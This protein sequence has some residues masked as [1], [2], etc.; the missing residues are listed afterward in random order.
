MGW[1]SVEKE[2]AKVKKILGIL[3][4]CILLV[5]FS[6]CIRSRVIITSNPSGA[7]VTF[8]RLYRGPTPIEIPIIWYWYYDIRLEKEGYKPLDAQERFHAPVWFYMP[9]DLFCEA[10]PFRIY[11]T[12][13]RHYVL[14]PKEQL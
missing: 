11:D 1:G 9:F 6:G 12:K 10:L 5:A 2:D 13:H 3:L 8:N 4:L 14:Q 7:D